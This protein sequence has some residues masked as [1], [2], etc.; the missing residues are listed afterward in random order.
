MLSLVFASLTSPR[1]V[2]PTILKWQIEMEV[3]VKAAFLVAAVSG[4]LDALARVLLP[5]P[6]EVEAAVMLSP[7][8]MAGIQLGSMF[9]VAAMMFQ[10]GRLFGGKGDYEG[11]LKTTVWISLVGLFL[12]AITLVL[13]AFVQP[14]GELFQL[15]TLIWMLVIFT[16]FIQ[17]LHGFESFFMTLA[18]SLGALFLLAVVIVILLTLFGLM[19]GTV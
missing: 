6:P 9:L 15:A 12:N 18:C 10:V 16:I 17:Q 11:A 1:E 19:P 7:I 8:A 13:L 14:F 4:L 5:L 2:A 3:V